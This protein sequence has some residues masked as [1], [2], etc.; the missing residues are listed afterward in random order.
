MFVSFTNYKICSIYEYQGIPTPK[1]GL[2]FFNLNEIVNKGSVNCIKLDKK[3]W[4]PH[5]HIVECYLFAQTYYWAFLAHDAI[6][7]KRSDENKTII[8]V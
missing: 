4:I 6:I 8:K 2:T 1:N 5:A 7:W 3:T